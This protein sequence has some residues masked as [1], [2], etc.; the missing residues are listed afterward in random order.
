[1]RAKESHQLSRQSSREDEDTSTA[2]VRHF[3]PEMEG[4]E[5]NKKYPIQINVNSWI[6]TNNSSDNNQS[7]IVTMQ[8]LFSPDLMKNENTESMLLINDDQARV[9][10][11][12]QDDNQ[13]EVVLKGT[14]SSTTTNDF[15]LVF[16]K[17][18]Q[19]FQL[20]DVAVSINGLK[21]DRQD[22]FSDVKNQIETSSEIKA[23]MNKRL[24]SSIPKAKSVN[25][26]VKP[27]IE[28][29]TETNP[30]PNT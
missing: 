17:E 24:K 28:T 4:I 3:E 16:A 1:V 18:T 23:K 15:L 20:Q 13:T 25:K 30:S 22:D 2:A 19:T 7:N 21:R 9:L 26:P 5:L 10:I 14:V 11:K 12:S 27:A 29:T 8:Y 6:K